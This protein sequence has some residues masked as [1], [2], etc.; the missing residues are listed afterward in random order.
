MFSQVTSSWE[1]IQYTQHLHITQ[2][3]MSIMPELSSHHQNKVGWEIT[4]KALLPPAEARVW[5]APPLSWL[6]PQPGIWCQGGMKVCKTISCYGWC[7]D[8]RMFPIARE[9]L[10]ENSWKT[11]H[12]MWLAER[13]IPSRN[14]EIVSVCRDLTVTGLLQ[15]CFAVLLQKAFTRMLCSSSLLSL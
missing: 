10:R 9:N 6:L 14:C 1:L 13:V 8:I 15:E 4:C 3:E 5:R 2:Y 7:G 11:Q 12:S